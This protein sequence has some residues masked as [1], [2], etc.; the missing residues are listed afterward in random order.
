MHTVCGNVKEQIPH[1]APEL[2]VEEVVTTMYEDANLYHDMLTG[3]AVT[4]ILHLLNVTKG[5]QET[6]LWLTRR[7]S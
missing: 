1:D 7:Q 2:L 5:K 4:G 3:Q 6:L